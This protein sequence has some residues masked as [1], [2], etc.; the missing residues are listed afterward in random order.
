M[1]DAVKQ[2][3]ESWLNDPAIAGPDKEEIRRLQRDGADK[4]L[5]DRFY[6][7]LE[8]GTGG[9]RGIIG[10]GRNR[11]NVYTVGAAA[12]GLANYISAQGPSAKQG[13]VVIA[14]DC[15]RMSTEFAERAACVMAANGIK[16]YLFE[17][18]RP[19]P[20]LSF[21]IRHLKATAG[22]VVTASHNPPE[23]NGFKAYWSDGVQV[24]PPHDRAIIDEVRR[25]GGFGNV[26]VMELEEA[27]GQGL[28][29]MIG[30]QVDEAF[31]E[32]VQASCINPELSRRQGGSLK[33]VYTSLHGT[34]GQLV[35]EALRLRGFA[36]V[37][38]VPEQAEPDGE[39]PT[40]KS[41]NPEE[42]PAL[43]MGIELARRE[44]ADLVIGT[45][46]DADRVGIAVR[47]SGGEFELITGNQVAALLTWYICEQLKQTGRFPG[48]AVLI[49]T[50]VSG[51]MMKT[52][53]RS[54][55]AD[56]IEVLTGFKW[57]GQ[58]VSRFESDARAGRPS[59]TYIF[60]A[61]ESYGYMPATFT[62]DKDAVTSAACI[63]DLAAAA[64]EQG[65]GLYELLQ[66]LFRQ[67]GYF[68]EETKNL[69]MPGADGAARIQG[70]MDTLRKN[71]PESIG[72]IAVA[73][74]ADLTTGEIRDRASGKVAGRYDLPSSNVLFYTLEDG[75]KVIARPSGTE[76]KIKFYVLTREADED[77]ARARRTATD[78]IRCIADDLVSKA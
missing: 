43:T 25:V 34:G 27:R 67:F 60:G 64:A 41:P 24:V 39:F 35:P 70:M 46:P 50:I 57:I 68:Q 32:Q 38:E 6:T 69:V 1:D 16:A 58:L 26:T 9:L 21:A 65:K 37:I 28:I 42:G 23:Y 51:D 3:I 30:R 11:M 75:T 63:A 20:E 56:V 55:G 61:E 76:P 15:R 77:L 78:R 53:A 36:N 4:E 59:R 17:K 72:G 10:A 5:T 14:Y 52:I 47:S 7:E 48:N 31:L 54:Y 33:I 71:P 22:I 66:D 12:Q 40:V 13:G 49:T 18:L 44:G 8:F 73:T 2:G 74:W 62:R 19:T 45:D 29:Q